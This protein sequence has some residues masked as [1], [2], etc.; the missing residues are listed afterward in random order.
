MRIL[1]VCLLLLPGIQ[2]AGAQTIRGKVTDAETN[3]ALIGAAIF[4][5]ATQSGAVTDTEG[6]YELEL[7]RAG[8]YRVS[9]SFLG[10]QSESRVV[11]VGSGYVTLNVSLKPTAIEAPPIVVTAKGQAS[12]VLSTPQAVSVVEGFVLAENRG[13]SALD[14]LEGVPGVR[15]LR[16]GASIAKPVIRGLSSQRVLVVQDGTRQEGQ[17]WGDEHGPELGSF[18][19]DRIE[20]LK[21]PASLLYG[22]DAIGGVVQ[23]RRKSLFEYTD[24]FAGAVIL[25]GLSNAR[26]GAGHARAG[27]NRQRLFYD[28][29]IGA[30]RAGS[31]DTPPGLVPNTGMSEYTGSVRAGRSIGRGTLEAGYRRFSS[32]IGLFEPDAPL[33]PGS[34]RYDIDLPYQRVSHD[35]VRA[36]AKF[37]VAGHRL[38]WISTWQ[39]NRRKEFGE[40]EEPAHLS[41]LLFSEPD[42]GHDPALYLRLSTLTSDVFIHHHPVGLLF[43]TFGLSGMYQRN[44]TLAEESLIPGARVWNAAA[45]VFE[46]LTLHRLTINGGVRLDVRRL[47]VEDNEELDVASQTRNYRAFSGAVGLA[48]QPISGLSAAVNAGRAWRAPVL[49]ELFGNGVH[50]GTIRFEQGN[51]SLRP[52]SSFSLDATLRW[53][54]EHIHLEA[55]GF[56]NTIDQF[57]VARQ[58]DRIDPASGYVV[59]AYSQT[60]ARLWGGEFTMDVHPHPLDWLHLSVT[61]DLTFTQDLATKEPLPLSPPFRTHIGLGFDRNRLGAF[62]DISI[63]MGPTLAAKQTRVAALEAPTE[64][65]VLWDVSCRATLNVGAVSVAPVLA[66]DNLLNKNYV[67]HLS[68]F[69]PYGIPDPGRNI[70]FEV[71]FSF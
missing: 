60:R 16:T 43:G 44:E 45:F 46:E 23:T 58:T 27:G 65:Y 67:S 14:A 33:L 52:E 28:A 12:D 10:F 51:A 35:A 34:D 9:I 24:P 3:E 13:V 48:W 66:I 7:A 53:F 2:R 5:P 47:D 29:S 39:Q 61:G 36:E 1:F 11:T 17:Q 54:S 59:Y 68:R 71:Q 21:G 22:S 56:A 41:A 69:K 38:E 64:G 31:Y 26:M 4:I 50:E 57:I 40:H 19:V 49:I 30:R 42:S 63:R 20:V 32:R 6:N 55:G 37:P 18:D 70:R 62:E 8:S 15:L 25:Q